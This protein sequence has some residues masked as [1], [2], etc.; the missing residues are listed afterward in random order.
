MSINRI[1]SRRKWL[2]LSIFISATLFSGIV[3]ADEADVVK[4]KVE[5]TGD[6]IYRFD[7][8]VRHN[9]EGWKHYADMWKVVLP[10]G[11]VVATR[12]LQHPHV[13]EQPF[14]RSMDGI[15]IPA[16]I[17]SVIVRVHDSVHHYGG[18]EA[19]V[20]LPH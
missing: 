12:V 17:D 4:V 8:T 18:K 7:V 15:K 1:L 11:R 19:I 6:H 13:G 3:L 9:D 2:A 14:T 20:K 10:D 5:R 16:G